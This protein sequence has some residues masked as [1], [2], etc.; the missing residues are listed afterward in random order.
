M[1]LPTLFLTTMRLTG[2][3]TNAFAASTNFKARVLEGKCWLDFVQ[4]GNIIDL[5]SI[6]TRESVQE[7]GYT[8]LPVPFN[9]QLRDCPAE[10][11]AM[12]LSFEGE[13]DRADDRLL[14]SGMEKYSSLQGVG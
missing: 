9:I 10:Y 8:T 14:A 11:P 2:A 13:T 7:K 3:V 1:K 4:S 6:T 5:G 12:S